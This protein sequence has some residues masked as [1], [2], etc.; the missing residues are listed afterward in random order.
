[1]GDYKKSGGFGVNRNN[2]NF[3]DRSSGGRPSFGG[4]RG[5]DRGGRPT[6]MHSAVCDECKKACQVPFRPNGDK[7]VYCSD[8]FGSKKE[9]GS[10]DYSKKDF[11]RREDRKPEYRGGY[12]ASIYREK[13]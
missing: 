2:N 7:P 4:N 8:C 6:Q 3:R 9:G 11:G 10:N 1:M 13:K 12:K 5:G